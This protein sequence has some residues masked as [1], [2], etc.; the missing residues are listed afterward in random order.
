MVRLID[1]SAFLEGIFLQPAGKHLAIFLVGID[2]TCMPGLSEQMPL[3]AGDVLIERG[4]HHRCTD[5]ARTATN[6]CRLRNLT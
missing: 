4:C 3:A 2:E 6:E 5:I 1:S